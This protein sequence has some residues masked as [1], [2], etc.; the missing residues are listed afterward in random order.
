[1][2]ILAIAALLPR[3]RN[4]VEHFRVLLATAYSACCSATPQ[5]FIKP[6]LKHFACQTINLA[7]SPTEPIQALHT[8][9]NLLI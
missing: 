8:P 6:P 9:S 4:S 7:C 1:M 5:R 2:S 3:H